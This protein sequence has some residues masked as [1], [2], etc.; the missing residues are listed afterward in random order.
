MTTF[1]VGLKELRQALRA[2]VVHAGPPDD[3]WWHRVRF[4][5]EPTGHVKVFASQGYTVGLGYVGVQD[6]GDGELADFDMAPAEVKDLLTLFPL[7]KDHADEQLLEVHLVGDEHVRVRD[8]SGLFPGKTVELPRMKMGAALEHV[9]PLLGRTVR[10]SA[11]HYLDGVMVVN[12]QWLGLFAT[13][14]RVYGE[15]LCLTPYREDNGKGRL[16]VTAGDLFI[17]MFNG[18]TGDGHDEGYVKAAV[19]DRDAWAQLLPTR[20]H[21]PLTDLEAALAARGADDEGDDDDED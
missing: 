11:K 14:A 7:V 8:V 20:S 3:D 15:A 10:P 12:G 1:T 5:L 17:G 13:A 2:V 9:L 18:R 4:Q 6:P 21:D 16:L 19:A